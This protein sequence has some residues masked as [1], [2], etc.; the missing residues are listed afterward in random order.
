MK[1]TYDNFVETEKSNKRHF[2][3]FLSPHK[4]D[5]YNICLGEHKRQKSAWR[6]RVFLQ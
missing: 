6:R 2:L 3:L 4:T 5:E 1:D